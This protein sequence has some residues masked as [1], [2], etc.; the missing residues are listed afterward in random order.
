MNDILA[1][2][3]QELKTNTDQKTQKSFQR[4]FKEQVKYWR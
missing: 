1:Q 2:I 3:R 4:F